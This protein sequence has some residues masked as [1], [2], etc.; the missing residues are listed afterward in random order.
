MNA[1][2]ADYAQHLLIKPDNNGK[3]P[4]FISKRFTDCT[5]PKIFL[6]I[7]LLDLPFEILNSPHEYA[8][9]ESRG[10]NIKAGCNMI[11]FKKY[12][13]EVTIS[14]KNNFMV[15]HRYAREDGRANP[16]E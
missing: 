12:I 14:L 6:A 10:V 2:I 8:A 9:D 16:S 13:K 1:F 11:L 15:T 4:S 3:R 5:G 7:C